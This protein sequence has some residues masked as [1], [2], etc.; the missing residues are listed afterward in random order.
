M[1]KTPTRA[2]PPC[3]MFVTNFSYRA[4]LSIAGARTASGRGD[5][6][7]AGAARPGGQSADRLCA[8]PGEKA[9]LGARPCRDV[10]GDGGPIAAP[11]LKAMIDVERDHAAAECLG[12]AECDDEGR[13]GVAAA[14]ESDRQ[15][16]LH[17]PIEPRV[18]RLNDH[19]RT[20][21]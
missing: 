7:V 6:R 13:Q 8:F 5:K 1:S 20:W 19:F 15:G 21:P 4:Q 18:E 16:L 9:E 14:G 17:R 3:Q 12:P 2:Y 10:G 11:R